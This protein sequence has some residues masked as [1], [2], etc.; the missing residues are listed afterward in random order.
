MKIAVI[1]QRLEALAILFASIYFYHRLHLNILLFAVLLLSFDIFMIGY[2]VNSKVG[3]Y[4]YNIGHSF[5][6]P[7]LLL[8]VGTASSSRIVIGFSLIWF[9]HI[10]LDRALGYGLKFTTGF[11]DTHLGRIGK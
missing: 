2:L 11:T 7:S 6:V 1:F 8:V 5:I 10:G 9:A 4:T 3:A